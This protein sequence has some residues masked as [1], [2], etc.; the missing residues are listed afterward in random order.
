MLS[1][2]KILLLVCVAAAA[3]VAV[4]IVK[5]N[6]RQREIGSRRPPE[7]P[8]MTHIRTVACPVCGAYVAEQGA[9]KCGRKDCPV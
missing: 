5:R 4:T 3:W 2:G 8:R 6:Q 7:G 1:F 9:A